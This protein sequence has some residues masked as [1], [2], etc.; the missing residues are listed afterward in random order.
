[1]VAGMLVSM[2]S[3]NRIVRRGCFLGHSAALLPKNVYVSPPKVVC[4]AAIKRLKMLLIRSIYAKNQ[5]KCVR[6]AATMHSARVH[7]MR[8]GKIS[9][10]NAALPLC[11][12]KKY[13]EANR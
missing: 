3:S 1:M 9:G 13:F 10:S 8:G 11:D 4:I 2:A 12:Q 5:Q 7:S 6:I